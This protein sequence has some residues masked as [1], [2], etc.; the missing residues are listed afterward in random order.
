MNTASASTARSTGMPVRKGRDVLESNPLGMGA[1]QFRHRR[2][3]GTESNGL[4]CGASVS[5]LVAVLAT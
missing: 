5:A 4:A 1:V 3:C 2:I